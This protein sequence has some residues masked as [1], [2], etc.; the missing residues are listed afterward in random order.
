[1][2]DLVIRGEV[3]SLKNA[4][5]GLAHSSLVTSIEVSS[6]KS[7]VITCSR[8]GKIGFWAAK[9]G[10]KM[11]SM[12][13]LSKQEEELNVVKYFIGANSQPYILVGGASGALSIF[14]INNNKLSYRQPEHSSNEITKI[15]PFNKSSKKVLVLNAD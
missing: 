4:N 14:D 8:D 9:E 10:F 15:I 2:W 3:A 13:R 5:G 1:M 12:F 11:L 6:D 7:T